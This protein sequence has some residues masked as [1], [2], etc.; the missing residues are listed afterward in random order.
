MAFKTRTFFQTIP[1][2][3]G[4][5]ASVPAK[6]LCGCVRGHEGIAA[7]AA[8]RAGGL[9]DWQRAREMLATQCST[10]QLAF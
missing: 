3:K 5:G 10:Q 4:A 2:K 9:F 1:H 7:A 8:D 6:N